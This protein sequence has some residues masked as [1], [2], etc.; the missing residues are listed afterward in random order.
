MNFLWHVCL[1]YCRYRS[2]VNFKVPFFL[3][4]SLSVVVNEISWLSGIFVYVFCFAGQT[5][6]KT[7]KAVDMTTFRP[8]QSFLALIVYV[9]NLETV[10]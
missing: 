7:D 2:A 4:L 1:Y 8:L 6:H 5:G 10:T 9:S 3:S